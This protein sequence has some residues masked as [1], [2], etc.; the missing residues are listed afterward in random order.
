MKRRT[1]E[2]LGSK[3]LVAD[4]AETRLSNYLSANVLA[5]LALNA[6][7]GWWW[8]DPAAAV[9]IAAFALWTGWKM[10]SEAGSDGGEV[11]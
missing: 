3:V 1:G 5:G 11:S 9:V 6:T 10:W 8:A 4:S 2:Q 7:L